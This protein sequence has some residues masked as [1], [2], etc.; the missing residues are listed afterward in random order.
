M[1]KHIFRSLKRNLLIILKSP[2][3]YLVVAF[4]ALMTILID[5][6]YRYEAGVTM[7]SYTDSFWN[8]L[9]AFVAG[10]YDI[11]VVTPIGRACSFIILITGILVFSTLTGKIA[12]MFMDMQMKKTRG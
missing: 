11:C 1:K 3:T 4:I 10:Y 12:S 5:V 6:V 8:F 9:I 2:V 7:E